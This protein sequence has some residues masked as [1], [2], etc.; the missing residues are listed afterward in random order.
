[1]EIKYSVKTIRAA[2][3]EAR[4]T[5]TRRGS[6]IIAAREPGKLWCVIDSRMWEDMKVEGVRPA[7][8]RYTAL[9]DIFSVPA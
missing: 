5:K 2:G 4:W 6:P 8:E 7:F 1:M 3:L 9:L